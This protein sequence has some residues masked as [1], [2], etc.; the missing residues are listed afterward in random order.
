MITDIMTEKGEYFVELIYNDNF[1]QGMING[2][3]DKEAVEHYLRADSIYLKN[4]A[5]IYALLITQTDKLEEKNFF[6][7]QI[8]FI[9]N[10][11]VEAHYVLANYVGK[12]YKE[13]VAAGDWYPTSDHYI[14]HM[15]YNV[16]KNG[17]ADA[18]A[19]MAPCPWIY[20]R[21]AEE[22][23]KRNT[24]SD[25]NPFKGW[26]EFYAGDLCDYCLKYFF[27]IVNNHA[28]NATEAQK[29]RLI[30]NFLESC[31][32]EKNFFNMSYVKERWLME[33]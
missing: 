23:L 31:E 32:H 6:L 4:F 8:D 19:A 12:D 22:I 14:K 11:E 28:E 2:T 21:V 15:Y 26:I 5:D 10:K 27:D 3:L 17:Y 24:I 30:K 29:K 7:E 18:I 9:L 13:I 20:K 33:V 25:D 16:L 1:I